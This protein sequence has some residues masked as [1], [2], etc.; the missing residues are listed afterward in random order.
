MK[1]VSCSKLGFGFF[2]WRLVGWGTFAFLKGILGF[3]VFHK[4][5]LVSL[6]YD[7]K[8][9]LGG[10][11]IL[12]SHLLMYLVG[13]LVRYLGLIRPCPL[14]SSSTSLPQ[15]YLFPFGLPRT[16][17]YFLFALPY[18]PFPYFPRVCP[19]PHSP[20][21]HPLQFPFLSLLNYSRTP[22]YLLSLPSPTIFP[23]SAYPT[24][25]LSL[26]PCIPLSLQFCFPSPLS[27]SPPPFYP[28][29]PSLFSFSLPIFPPLVP[30]FFSS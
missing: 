19:H 24:L 1:F 16:F 9:Y 22:L 20:S 13:W 18:L 27:V 6:V 15:I 23:I 14:V 29:L 12:L 7:V 4:V 3:P 10:I 28:F 17:P 11:R 8:L 21:Y 2:G 30:S 5:F 26:L 25:S